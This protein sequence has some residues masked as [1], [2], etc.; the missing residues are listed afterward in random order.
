M[1]WGGGGVI[2]IDLLPLVWT[3]LWKHQAC[4]GW[5][6]HTVSVPTTSNVLRVKLQDV[7][8]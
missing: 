3:F 5:T 1:A 4:G 7:L 6:P 8:P 2:D